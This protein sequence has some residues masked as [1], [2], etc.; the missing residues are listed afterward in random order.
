MNQYKIFIPAIFAISFGTCL[1]L[2]FQGCKTPS[3]A[4]THTVYIPQP[5]IINNFKHDT[6]VEKHMT[7]EQYQMYLQRFYKEN[8]NSMF[9]PEFKRLS[10]TIQDQAVSIQKL[11]DLVSNVRERSIRKTDSMRDINNKQQTQLLEYQRGTYERQKEAVKQNKLQIGDL[12]SLIRILLIGG[13]VLWL[14]MLG[15]F[16]YNKIQFKRITKLYRSIAND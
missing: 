10:L 13:G 14:G 7:P 12:N 15:L 16:I 5:T 11:T 9:A 4:T 8:F 3:L 6:L 1:G 2:F